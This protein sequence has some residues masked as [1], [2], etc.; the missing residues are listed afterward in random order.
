[1]ELAYKL[2]ILANVIIF[3]YTG[4]ILW[5]VKDLLRQLQRDIRIVTGYKKYYEERARKEGHNL[6]HPTPEEL[7]GEEA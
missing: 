5:R 4:W 2:V 6:P 1:M 7:E 3:A